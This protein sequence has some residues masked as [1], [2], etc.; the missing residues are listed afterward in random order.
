MCA[1]LYAC[2]TKR[3]ILVLFATLISDHSVSLPSSVV[4]S[5]FLF[6]SLLYF[7]PLASDIFSINHRLHKAI[8]FL[9]SHFLVFQ[10]LSIRRV[11]VNCHP[12]QRIC[13]THIWTVND[14]FFKQHHRASFFSWLVA[15]ILG[16]NFL[17]FAEIFVNRSTDHSMHFP[18]LVETILKSRNFSWWSSCR[19]P[20]NPKCWLIFKKLTLVSASSSCFPR[21][22]FCHISPIISADN[23]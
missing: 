3:M 14:V 6:L 4:I 8:D 18:A 7:W 20:R 16:L 15:P 10:E 1:K 22:F 13:E 21:T 23:C 9:N 2:I 19:R 5:V 12:K 17:S 11:V